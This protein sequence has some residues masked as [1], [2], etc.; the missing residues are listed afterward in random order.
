MQF[1]DALQSTQTCVLLLHILED[2]LVE[3]RSGEDGGDGHGG[4]AQGSLW[5]G[6]AGGGSSR[7]FRRGSL[8]GGRLGL[9][10]LGTLL[11]A[12]QSLPAVLA[13]AL[14]VGARALAVASLV[15]RGVTLRA[16]VA[17]GAGRALALLGVEV[18]H[19]GG[20]LARQLALVR[21]DVVAE[22]A[23]V[24]DVAA[25]H[26]RQRADRVGHARALAA[27]EQGRVAGGVRAEA[28][29]DEG[30]RRAQVVRELRGLLLAEQHL[31]RA[32][33]EVHAAVDH[34]DRLAVRVLRAGHTDDALA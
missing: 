16:L 21:V 2:R 6:T 4:V 29:L 30:R 22:V 17:R 7:A 33:V 25:A 5:H 20:A 14:L 8:A 12:L 19:T 23:A 10:L 28:V 9:F 13:L 24:A 18:A 1:Q 32:R 26:V 34:V 27:A 31:E 15:R 11:R 3:D